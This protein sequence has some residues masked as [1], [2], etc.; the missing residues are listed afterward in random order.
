MEPVTPDDEIALEFMRRAAMPVRQ[1]RPLAGNLQ[2][3][4]ILGLVDRLKPGGG[5]GLHE[6]A[7]LGRPVDDDRLA[8]RQRVEIDPVAQ[9]GGA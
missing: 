2:R 8:R 6:V 7:H 1:A 5:P 3:R 9:A 4:H